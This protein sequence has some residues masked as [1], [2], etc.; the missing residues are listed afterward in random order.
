LAGGRFSFGPSFGSDSEGAG[1]LSS[2]SLG[3]FLDPAKTRWLIG[4]VTWSSPAL[5]VCRVQVT[6]INAVS[7]AV[8]LGGGGDFPIGSKSASVPS[9]GSLVLVLKTKLFPFGIVVGVLPRLTPEGSIFHQGDVTAAGIAGGLLREPCHRNFVSDAHPNSPVP[10]FSSH[11]PVDLLTTDQFA[12]FTPLGSGILLTDSEAFL[13]VNELCGLFLN[14]WDSFGRLALWNMDFDAASFSRQVRS[15]EGELFDVEG[16]SP[17]VWEAL[18][19]YESGVDVA[20]EFDPADVLRRRPVGR[21]DL[22]EDDRDLVPFWRRLSFGGYLG[23]GGHRLLCAPPQNASGPV[24]MRDR[25][26]PIGLFREFVELNGAY[27]LA[28]AKSICLAKRVVLPVPVQRKVVE[29]QKDGDGVE[30]G[31]RFSGKFGDGPEHKI[32]DWKGRDDPSDALSRTMAG[33]DDVRSRGFAWA[34]LHPFDLHEKDW[35]VSEEGENSSNPMKRQQAPI[36]FGSASEGEDVRPPEPREVKVD[37]RTPK[38]K[39]YE[40]ESFI[41]L[42]DTGDVAISNGYGAEILLCGDK[43]RIRAPGG[44]ELDCGRTI[45]IRAGDDLVLEAQN[46]ADLVATQKDLRLKAK[47]NLHALAGNPDSGSGV[48][49]GGI[50]LESRGVGGSGSE[51]QVGEDLTTGGVVLRAPHA[52]ITALGKRIYLRTG[53]EEEGAPP[54]GSLVL[55]AAKGEADVVVH[56]L[57]VRRYASVQFVDSFIRQSQVRAANVWTAESS[58]LSGDVSVGGS[59]TTVTGGILSAQTVQVAGGH[60]VTSDPSEQ[61]GTYDGPSLAQAR[62]VLRTLAQY[63]RQAAGDSQAGWQADFS[64]DLYREPDGPGSRAFGKRVVFSFRD[65]DRQYG[66]SRLV[67]PEPR[68]FRMAEGSTTQSWKPDPVRRSSGLETWPWPGRKV[69]QGET[70][71]RGKSKLTDPSTGN[72]LSRKQF[73]SDYESPDF[74]ESVEKVKFVENWKV[75]KAD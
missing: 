16:S 54:G 58:I 3:A 45:S 36:D 52:P 66:S 73:R 4:S 35:E 55:D 21:L 60:I 15:D 22:P 24:R 43:I 71:L 39:F 53:V 7:F 69:M 47:R 1:V 46:S 63:S 30:G 6:G 51:N 9:P 41:H 38:T 44:I 50:L 59:L 37:H 64:S 67:V 28:S 25:D 42:T 18:G 68:W 12:H 57:S 62:A 70:L 29:D 8:C 2:S 13:R 10:D 19:A 56:G 74:G 31:Y 14:Y 20:A 27:W 32:D 65:D 17:Y 75:L 61:V 40:T 23:Q 48:G 26:E 72:A 49:V 34:A 5:G 33:L 11:Q